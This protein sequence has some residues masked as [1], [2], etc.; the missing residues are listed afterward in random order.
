ML[1][2]LKLVVRAE[3]TSDW[4]LHLVGMSRMLNLF[5]ATGH[6]N[7]AKCARLYLQMM[8]LA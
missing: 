6:I 3:R 4:N 1:K 5:A 7:Y 8:L 2:H